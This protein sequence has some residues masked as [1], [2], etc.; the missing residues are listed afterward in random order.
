[1]AET[2]MAISSVWQLLQDLKFGGIPI[3][4]FMLMV[5][6]GGAIAAFLRGKKG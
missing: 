1:M 3:L 5:P 4:Y 6:V 2:A